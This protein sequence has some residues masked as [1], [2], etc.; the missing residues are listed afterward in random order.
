MTEVNGYHRS[1]ESE[2]RQ[3]RIKSVRMGPRRQGRLL[4][5]CPECRKLSYNLA[6]HRCGKTSTYAGGY[7]RD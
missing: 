2:R 7:G 1:D 4:Y 5:Q 3:R 6:A